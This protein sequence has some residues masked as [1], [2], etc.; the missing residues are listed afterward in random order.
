MIQNP[1]GHAFGRGPIAER[2]PDRTPSRARRHENGCTVVAPTPADGTRTASIQTACR[3]RLRST[4]FLSSRTACC[5]RR[6]RRQSHPSIDGGSAH[7]RIEWTVQATGSA[8]GLGE[9]RTGTAAGARGGEA[10][11]RRG[12]ED[13]Q[14]R[15]GRCCAAATERRYCAHACE[16]PLLRE[17]PWQPPAPLA[18]FSSGG[19]R[20]LP[21][22]HAL[23]FLMSRLLTTVRLV[24]YTCN[25]WSPPRRRS[26]W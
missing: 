9:P 19:T 12:Q 2:W 24:I 17:R 20:G 22:A 5:G 11:E 14:A 1:K 26:S 13:V 21:A 25:K 6:C 15:P 8:N 7:R 16:Q 18:L 3:A 10:A 23:H 4:V